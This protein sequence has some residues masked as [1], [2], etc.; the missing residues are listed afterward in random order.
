VPGHDIIVIG[1]SAGGVEALTQLVKRL[2]EDLPASVFVVLHIPPDGSSV[3]AKIL[4]R[5]GPLP[6]A[7]PE[8]RERIVPGRIYVAGPDCHLLVKRRYV[9]LVRGPK[10]NGHRP[11]VDPLFRT[12]ARNYGPRVVG[13]VLSGTRDDGTAGLMAIKTSG[14]VAIVQDLGEALYV[15]MPRSAL[16]NVPV[17]YAMP[18]ADIGD[19]L[20][21]LASEPVEEGEMEMDDEMEQEADI[22]EFELESLKAERR[23]G[24]PSRFTC[25]ECQGVLFEIDEDGLL[26]FRCRVGHAYSSESLLA[27]QSVM[28]EAA[29]WA[30]LRSLEENIA[31]ARRLS[32]RL[33]ERGN[34]R[35]AATFHA[36][37]E[38]LEERVDVIR[39]V[40]IDQEVMLRPQMNPLP[41]L[42]AEKETR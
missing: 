4:N 7:V 11:A 25:P 14:G 24:I 6:A 23:P 19:L 9:R 28:L 1:A 5:A 22:A 36:Q 37:A 41:D 17:D 15:S 27:E 8:D 32:Q 10:E 35:S 34:E 33:R 42:T 29:L 39:K 18:V 30:A 16:E 2:P 20:V 12:A 21:Q 26:R 40:L 31:L 3:L 13:V 38:E